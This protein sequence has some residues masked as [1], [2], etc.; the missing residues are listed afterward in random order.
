MNAIT[1]ASL[2]TKALALRLHDLAGEERAI[3]VDFLLH[4]DEF[5]RRRAYLEE[6]YGSLWDWCLRSLHLREC[7]AGLRI[8][9]MRVLRK[10][11]RLEP[12]LRD[13]RLCMSTLTLLGQVL[14]EE[15]A[16]EL[17]ARATYGTKAEV[18]SLVASVKPRPAPADGVRRLPV[19]RPATAAAPTAVP[20]DGPAPAPGLTVAVPP[21]PQSGERP[22]PLAS[23]LAPAV[24]PAASC[25]GVP[26]AEMRAVSGDRWSLRVSIDRGL[27]DELETLTMLL[28]HVLPRGDLAAVLREA[29][30]CGIEKHGKRKGAVEAARRRSARPQ[31]PE[32]GR[33]PRAIPIEVRRA[34]WRR[35]G[36]RCT[37]T[38]PDG[39]RCDSRW[40]LEFD[41]VESPLI[42][43]RSTVENVRLRCRGHN[44]L[45]AEEVYGRE[46]MDRFRREGR[47]VP[48]G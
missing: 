22:D 14:T 13:G 26:A 47:M 40:Q 45:Y 33:N 34:V 6:G 48:N 44:L 20:P 10:F 11:P 30:R 9:A 38:T 8:A 19:P 16:D 39:R 4:L 27:K 24:A 1:I 2:D 18:D 12:A 42:G 21:G 41:H 35:D 43:G 36:G 28:S 15:N 7:A 32:A 23:D 37:W 31:A 46:H 5:D 17:L 3:Q 25:H 29:I